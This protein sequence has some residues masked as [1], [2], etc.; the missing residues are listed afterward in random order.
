VLI[1]LFKCASIASS[2]AL[3]SG[4]RCYEVQ[5]IIIK[6]HCVIKANE[7]IFTPSQKKIVTTY[8][9]GKMSIRKV[10][11]QFYVSK[12]LVQKLVKQ[13]QTERNLQSKKRGKPQFSH[14]TSKSEEVRSLVAEHP[15]GNAGRVV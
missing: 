14:L 12:T 5:S 3:Y 6:Y 1:N 9:V 7:S 8:L 11:D 10:A 2:N 13:Q 15:D 4:S